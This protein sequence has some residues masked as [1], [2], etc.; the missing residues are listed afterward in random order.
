[1][2]EP[3]TALQRLNAAM[4]RIANAEPPAASRR[5]GGGFSLV[6]YRDDEGHAMAQVEW[7]LLEPPEYDEWA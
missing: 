7:E 5:H 6:A 1:M 3:R 4:D 2:T